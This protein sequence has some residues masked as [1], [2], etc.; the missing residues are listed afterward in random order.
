[1]MDQR[2]PIAALKNGSGVEKAASCSEDYKLV[3]RFQVSDCF[4]NEALIWS[5]R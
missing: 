2:S 3:E 5:G 1:M 4:G